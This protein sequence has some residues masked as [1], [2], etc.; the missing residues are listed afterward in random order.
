MDEKK[1]SEIDV[2]NIDKNPR[3]ADK[4]DLANSKPLIRIEENTKME[5]PWNKLHKI[6][7]KLFGGLLSPVVLLAI[8]GVVSYQKSEKAIMDNYKLMEEGSIVP[9]S[10]ILKQLQGIKS[11]NVTFIIIACILA[12]IVG[13]IIGIGINKGFTSL[14]MSLSQAAKGDLTT[15]FDTKRKDEFHILSN[16]I[17][18]MMS[19]LCKSI[20]E[21]QVVG[22][23]VSGLAGGLS[24]TSEE[25][26]V[27]TKNISNTIGDIEQGIVQQ[28]SDTENCFIQMT[29]LCDQINQVNILT[30]EIEQIA[31]DTKAISGDG[32]VIIDELSNKSKA[33]SDITQNVI[34]KIQ[35]FE[36]Q[37]KNIEGFVKIINQ[38]ASQTNLLSLNA[39]IEAARAGEAGLGFAVVA[40]E[41][42]K[43]ADQSVQ[44][45]SKIQI[46]VKEIHMKTKDTVETAMMAEDIVESQT[47]SLSKTVSM[48]S[49]INSHV[50]NLVNNL[51][52]ITVGMKKIDSA[53]EETLVGISN[54][55]AISQQTAA[56]SEVM[57]ST[58]LNQIDSVEYL[59]QSALELANDTKKLEKAINLFKIN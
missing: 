54:I 51:D 21:A 46:I 32:I 1:S 55:S 6:S 59:R 17:T 37:S 58:A 25:L 40:D 41:I 3:P 57:S 15:K 24:E 22:S 10:A 52:N 44:A 39:S 49:N 20:G 18:N 29:N 27:A 56:S 36:A 38:I 33:T 9:Q 53:I 48:F 34:K 19:D 14:R 2:L 8:Y 11:L 23:R 5:T 45:A 12:V 13:I 31:N 4:R 30:N 50:N 47:E 35:E 16:E 26:F 28:A 42:R 7:I 43:L